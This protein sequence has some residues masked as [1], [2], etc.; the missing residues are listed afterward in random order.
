MRLYYAHFP[1]DDPPK[2]LGV[3]LW[4]EKAGLHLPRVWT[5]TLL[6]V[7]WTPS[8][9]VMASGLAPPTRKLEIPRFKS[10]RELSA[11][12]VISV[13]RRSRV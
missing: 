6:W 3:A 5:S 13:L 9:S 11:G 4:A 12:E 1:L 7:R 8:E 2:V 10:M